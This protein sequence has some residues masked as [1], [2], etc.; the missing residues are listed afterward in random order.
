MQEENKG[1]RREYSLK[2]NER[3]F[4]TN[5]TYIQSNYRKTYTQNERRYKKLSHVIRTQGKVPADY[6][7][8]IIH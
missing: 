8:K 7:L 6:Q 5:T 4:Q 1:K 3:K 2:V